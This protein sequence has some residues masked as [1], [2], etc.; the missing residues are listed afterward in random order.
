MK[1]V[2][3]D[4]GHIAKLLLLHKRV[5]SSKR[6][7]LPKMSLCQK[8]HFARNVTLP[9]MSL[10]QKCHF[11]KNVTLPKSVSLPKQLNFAKTATTSMRNF[12]KKHHFTNA[13]P[14]MS[15]NEIVGGPDCQDTDEKF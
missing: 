7:T 3:T 5:T 15:I 14:N 8:C 11:V 1:E 6:V 4:R 13:S 9:K 10:C 2:I 12:A